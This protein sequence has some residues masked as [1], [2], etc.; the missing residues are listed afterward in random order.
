MSEPTLAD[1]EASLVACAQVLIDAVEA[2]V[3]RWIRDSVARF[4]ASLAYSVATDEA[5]RSGERAI[6][7]ELRDLLMSDIDNQRIGPLQVLRD[8]VRFANSVLEA[9]GVSPVVRDPFAER[10]FPDDHYG[11]A[12]AAFGDIDP[13][14]HE[15]GLIWGAAKAHVHLRRRREQAPGRDL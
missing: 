15:P 7:A 5:V 12:P 1:D 3:G 6:S 4:D 2:V 11:L 10:S 8:G 13:A 14:L 9:A